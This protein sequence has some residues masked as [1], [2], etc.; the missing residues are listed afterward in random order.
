[1]ITPAPPL[2]NPLEPS[3]FR[4][5]AINVFYWIVNTFVGELEVLYAAVEAIAA[6]L[7]LNDVLD[8]SV[9]SLTIGSGTKSLTVS[10]S[11]SFA[12]GM[13]LVIASTAAP[14]TDSMVGQVT[15]Y[16]SGTGALVVEV[17][18]IGVFG[19][20]T[21][22]DW[23]ISITA[24]MSSQVSAVMQPVTS[25]ASLSAARDAMGVTTAISTAVGAV[26]VAQIQPLTASAIG[27]DL[28]IT[29]APTKLDFR[30]TSLPSGSISPLTTV[31]NTVLTIVNGA[32]LGSSNGVSTRFEVVAMK[33]GAT[34]ELAA[35]NLTGGNVTDDTALLS[36]TAMTTSS[37]ST[38]TYYSAAARSNLPQRYV[39]FVEL[40]EATAGVYASQPTKVQG[41]GGTLT[42]SLEKPYSTKSPSRAAG[43]S[44]TNDTKRIRYVYVS[45]ASA[46]NSVTLSATVAGIGI[47]SGGGFDGNGG[48]VAP[49]ISFS[50]M[51]G[52]VY[53]VSVGGTSISVWKEQD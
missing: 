52:E 25:A 6:S 24:A 16:N 13:W 2:P 46:S 50:V 36:T 9:T 40:S 53:S 7:T 29:L 44:Y 28:V 12:P 37:D 41:S 43:T 1:M 31:A 17:P 34:L 15:S 14:S 35:A 8:T 26:N 48:Q 11:K 33:N 22:A 30:D 51:P 47:L 21:I 42:R 20:G 23:T 5:R 39:G 10:A 19:S 38:N 4:T 45:T 27:N 3:S 32:T 18:A 49:T